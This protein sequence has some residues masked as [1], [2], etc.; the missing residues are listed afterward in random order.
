MSS[1]NPVKG[2]TQSNSP[3]N[4]QIKKPLNLKLSMNW[5]KN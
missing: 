3:Q 4:N 5:V 1:M 2:S